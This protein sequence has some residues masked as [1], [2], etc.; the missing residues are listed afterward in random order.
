MAG[1]G[2]PFPYR[3]SGGKTRLAYSAWIAGQVAGPYNRF[4]FTLPLSFTSGAPSFG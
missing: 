3:T 4:L 2:G 1:P